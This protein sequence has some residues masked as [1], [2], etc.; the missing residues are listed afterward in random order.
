MANSGEINIVGINPA[1]SFIESAELSGVVT[2]GEESAKRLSEKLGREVKPGEQFD[3]GVLA[4]FN[5][6]PQKQEEAKNKIK[7]NIFND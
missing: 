3:L 7:P 6:D 5:R 1:H 2:V 4:V